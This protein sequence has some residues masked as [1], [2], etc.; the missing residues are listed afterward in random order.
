MLKP[1]DFFQLHDENG[2][3]YY[4]LAT[5]V[6]GRYSY[7]YVDEN[8]VT[9]FKVTEDKEVYEVNE[10]PE[11]LLKNLGRNK[12]VLS[13]EI[14]MKYIIS[15]V[16]AG[17]LTSYE[18]GELF[19]LLERFSNNDSIYNIAVKNHFLAKNAGSDVDTWDLIAGLASQCMDDLFTMVCCFNQD[20]VIY[21]LRTVKK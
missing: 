1:N 11:N 17:P 15:R 3:L 16:E 8:E 19:E 5:K 21:L 6:E 14:K 9:L 12:A 13:V 4:Q 20:T 10:V 2:A 18:E 7:Y